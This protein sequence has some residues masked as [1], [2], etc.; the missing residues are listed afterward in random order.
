MTG[1]VLSSTKPPLGSRWVRVD[2]QAADVGARTAE[3]IQRAIP[4]APVRGLLADSNLDGIIDSTSNCG[5]QLLGL[6]GGLANP[7]VSSIDWQERT[8]WIAGG[9]TVAEVSRELLAHGWTLKNLAGASFTTLAGALALDLRGP[10]SWD[11]DNEDA[12][13]HKI[14]FVD[15]RGQL[16]QL[17]AGGDSS[18]HTSAG[19]AGLSLTGICTAAEVPIRPVSTGWMIVDS[20]RHSTADELFEALSAPEVG[21]YSFARIDPTGTGSGI[22][23][24]T[25]VTGRHAKVL[26]L[27]EIRR[28]DALKYVSTSAARNSSAL[29]MRLA[30]IAGNNILQ[31]LTQR[32]EP[33]SRRDELVPMSTFFHLSAEARIASKRTNASLT[34]AFSIP[35]A[36]ADLVPGFLERL[37]HIGGHGDHAT[38]QRCAESST[39]PLGTSVDGWDFAIELACDTPGLGRMLDDWDERVAAAGGQVSL[40]TDSRMRPEAVTAMYPRLAEWH[41]LRDELDPGRHFCSNLSRRLAL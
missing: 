28:P 38:V 32:A 15:G 5:G 23:R 30:T 37:A 33:A 7:A 9:A 8:A 41:Q 12:A 16:R 39:G 13:P 17:N 14:D 29:P 19:V 18:S 27:P 1:S 35:L 36:H 24:G 25:A 3:A 10:R 40:G 21:T 26:D 34:Y 2:R 31:N 4:R 6:T 22:G 20:Q 11:S